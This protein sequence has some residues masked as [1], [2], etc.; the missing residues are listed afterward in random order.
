MVLKGVDHTTVNGR[1][2]E[3]LGI[4]WKPV[5]TSEE[6]S[7][8]VYLACRISSIN[9]SMWVFGWQRTADWSSKA[10]VRAT[11]KMLK[12]KTTL[13][14]YRVWCWEKSAF[15]TG[16]NGWMDGPKYTYI[17]IYHTY[18]YLYIYY[19][20]MNQFIQVVWSLATSFREMS[21]HVKALDRINAWS[22][23]RSLPQVWQKQRE[24]ETKNGVFLG[25]MYNG[26]RCTRWV[27]T[28][29]AWGKH[30]LWCSYRRGME[31]LGQIGWVLLMNKRW[32]QDY[33]PEV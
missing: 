8:Q 21:W 33:P 6:K 26:Y 7:I 15:R 23:H 30:P 1:N 16:T 32:L 4:Y 31:G 13:L 14:V 11:L 24:F 19:N 2:P 9:G 18:M 22:K 3:P 29:N 28:T 20:S 12:A 25:E 5:L 17:Y 10:G 27:G